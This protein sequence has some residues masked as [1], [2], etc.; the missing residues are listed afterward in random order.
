MADREKACRCRLSSSLIETSE[1]IAHR[2][3]SSR[4]ER[5]SSIAV[6]SCVSSCYL[7]AHG[8]DRC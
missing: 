7:L 4:I 1:L 5:E 8:D 2:Y 6:S 3:S